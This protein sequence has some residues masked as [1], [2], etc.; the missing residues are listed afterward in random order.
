MA[1]RGGAVSPP[2]VRLIER[3]G[4][5]PVL[6]GAI[7]LLV[8]GLL[9]LAV[10][11]NCAVYGLAWVLLGLGMGA[12]LYDVAFATCGRYFDGPARD[13]GRDPVGSRASP[14]RNIRGSAPNPAKRLALWKPGISAQT[15]TVIACAARVR[16][17]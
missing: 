6:T 5:R 7:A 14:D 11:P 1:P 16:P 8:L 4:G 9:A 2:V 3:P 15:T 10:A 12:D 17:V 13:H